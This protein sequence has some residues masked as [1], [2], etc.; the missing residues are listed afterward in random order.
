MVTH[1]CNP[2]TQEA[3]GTRTENCRPAWAYSSILLRQGGGEKERRRERGW[4]RHL[5]NFLIKRKP[6]DFI[7]EKRTHFVGGTKI[8]FD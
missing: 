5:D 6:S 8:N 2:R 7:K 4:E 1:I 3:E